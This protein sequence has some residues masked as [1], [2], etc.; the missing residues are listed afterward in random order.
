MLQEFNLNLPKRSF[1]VKIYQQK[2]M[3]F[4]H[5]GIIGIDTMLIVVVWNGPITWWYL[6]TADIHTLTTTSI[7]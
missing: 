2:P 4:V 7:G 3:H 5:I 1:I 6:W